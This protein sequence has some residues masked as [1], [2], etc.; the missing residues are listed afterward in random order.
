MNFRNRHR[1]SQI[2]DVNLVPLIDVLMSVLT[3]FIIISMTFT[4]Q[5]ILQIQLPTS[6]TPLRAKGQKSPQVNPLV[7]GLTLQ[8]KIILDNQPANLEQLAARIQTYL[9]NNPQGKIILSADRQLPY[10]KISILLKQMGNMG[11]DRVSLL[12]Q[13]Q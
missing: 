5:Q 2:P 11:G 4:G 10:A 1:S 12:L 13:D 3:F 8:G 6:S 7:V 9:I